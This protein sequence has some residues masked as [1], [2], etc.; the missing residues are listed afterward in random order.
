MNILSTKAH[1]SSAFPGLTC[2]PPHNSHSKRNSS[3]IS[4]VP[5]K[6][7]RRF[8]LKQTQLL[9]NILLGE[10]LTQD[11]WRVSILSGPSWRSSGPPREIRTGPQL[12]PIFPFLSTSKED[13]WTEERRGQPRPKSA[14]AGR[15]RGKVEVGVQN[16]RHRRKRR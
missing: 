9:F 2:G 5:K 4:V 15:E 14:T 8:G 1:E 16:S 6:S 13:F 10:F 12:P 7:A 3:F 11:H